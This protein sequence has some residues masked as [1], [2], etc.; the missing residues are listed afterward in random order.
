MYHTFHAT[1]AFPQG[2]REFC[3]SD[4]AVSILDLPK[5]KWVK[6]Y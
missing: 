2:I 6:V 3:T 1:G 5:P 4:L